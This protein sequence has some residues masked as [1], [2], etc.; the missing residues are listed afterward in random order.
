MAVTVENVTLVN[1]GRTASYTA[2]AGSN[3]LRMVLFVSFNETSSTA[4]TLN[5]A[6]FGGVACTVLGVAR[7][8]NNSAN[9]GISYMLEE[10]IPT[11]SQTYDP[12]W[13]STGNHCNCFITLDGVDQAGP[14][15]TNQTDGNNGSTTQTQLS[16]LSP[17]VGDLVM[18]LLQLTGAGRTITQPFDTS[19]INQDIAPD[20]TYGGASIC[21]ETAAGTSVDAKH[22]W[23]SATSAAEWGLVIK[24]DG[25]APSIPSGRM[26]MLGVG[27]GDISSH[28]LASKLDGVLT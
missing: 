6:T 27:A 9:L 3:S 16:N 26:L 20:S 28:V 4:A 13:S 17:A 25:V 14:F 22:S 1:S 5:S 15:G 19:D 7:S 12:T 11:G 21:H 2:A 18:S 24:P 8:D 23:S 10:D